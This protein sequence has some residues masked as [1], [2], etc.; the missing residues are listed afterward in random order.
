MRRIRD[1][2]G[3]VSHNAPSGPLVIPFGEPDASNCVSVPRY[4]MRLIRPFPANHMLPSGPAVMA[5]SVT[6][7]LYG[8]KNDATAPLDTVILPTEELAVV[9]HTVP[10]GPALIQSGAEPAGRENSVTTPEGVMRAILWVPC[11]VSQ[12]SP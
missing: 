5:P 9:N 10:L 8:T 1:E 3:S 11:K 7:P 2:P 6:D 12:R 4:V